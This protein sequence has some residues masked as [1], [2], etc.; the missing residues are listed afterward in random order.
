MH[1][2]LLV[3]A[4]D[5]AAVWRRP[6]GR[7]LV[8]TVDFFA[9]VVDDASTWGRIAAANA[10]SDVYAMG[11]RP[12]FALNLV[13][14]P[15]ELLPLDL[16]AEVLAGGARTAAE[17]GWQIVGGHTTEGPEPVYGQAVTGEVD[18]DRLMRSSGARPGELLVLTKPLGTG[19]ITTAHKRLPPGDAGLPASALEAATDEMCRLNDTASALAAEAGICGSTDVTGFGLLGH[20]AEMCASSR[21]GAVVEVAAVPLLREVGTLAG[22]GHVP[23]GTAR[24]IAAVRPRLRFQPPGG[25]TGA[26]VLNLLADPQTSGGLLLS[27][28]RTSADDLVDA[29]AGSGHTAAIIGETTGSIPA[30]EIELIPEA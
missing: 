28:P 8:S 3:G 16:L 12:L 6:D 24:N 20:L 4:G 17:G 5:D 25:D 10:A 7:A 11:G 23:G 18:P 13:V 14:W 9:P 29:L 22:A 15:R 27:C 26:L 1:P 21:L 19:V 2:D 30:G